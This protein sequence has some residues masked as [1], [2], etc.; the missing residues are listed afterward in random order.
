M[1]LHERHITSPGLTDWA[2]SGASTSSGT[3]ASGGAPQ[4][5]LPVA[6]NS[7]GARYGYKLLLCVCMAAITCCR[8]PART[9]GLQA[10]WPSLAHILSCTPT[11][12][13]FPKPPAGLPCRPGLC[14][15]ALSWPKGLQIWLAALLVPAEPRR[16]QL[17]KKQTLQ[18]QLLITTPQ[19]AV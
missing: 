6:C 10:A 15:Q 19:R 1:E 8:V 7:S 3:C 17:C 13:L 4:Q 5:P 18:R 2:V 12:M 14:C 9:A 11:C 16:L